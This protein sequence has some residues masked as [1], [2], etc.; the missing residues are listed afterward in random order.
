VTRRS[1]VAFRGGFFLLMRV[2]TPA[3]FLITFGLIAVAGASGY[4]FGR[5]S[6]PVGEV[7]VK[8]GAVDEPNQ[9]RDEVARLK[10]ENER[11]T[12]TVSEAI[13]TSS[14]QRAV[15]LARLRALQ[16]AKLAR[17]FN[18]SALPF[19]LTDRT[20]KLSPMFEAMFDLSPAEA[21]ALDGALADGRQKLDRLLA[22]NATVTQTEGSVVVAVKPFAEGVE[23][24]DALMDSFAQTLGPERN[25][26]F[27]ELQADQLSQAFNSFGAEMR[28]VNLSRGKV[29]D[30]EFMIHLNETR[31]GKNSSGS[32]S[33]SYRDA[34]SFEEE[35][36]WL[37]PLVPPLAD[38]PVNS[39]T[40]QPPARR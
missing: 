16:D 23:I 29:S 40:T 18:P 5:Q 3:R 7:T 10:T 39:G 30:G 21:A 15:S 13:A 27:V 22:A 33:T 26:L 34:A 4:W 6:S 1:A 14:E 11:L 9:W 20:G 31:K 8:P 17:R 35:Q 28:T 36:A 12:K 32:R 24:Y 25:A 38:L 37:I 19:P 2:S